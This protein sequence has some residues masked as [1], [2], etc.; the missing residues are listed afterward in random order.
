MEGAGGHLGGSGG[1]FGGFMEGAGASGHL[2][3]SGGGF[4]GFMEGAGASGHLGGGSGGFGGLMEGAGATGH[5]GGSRDGGSGGVG[6]MAGMGVGGFCGTGCA[7]TYAPPLDAGQYMS[8]GATGPLPG[9]L[10]CESACGAYRAVRWRDFADTYACYYDQ[11]GSLVSGRVMGSCS[12]PASFESGP[13]VFC[14][15]ADGGGDAASGQ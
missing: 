3:G 9:Q 12:N 8:C 4:A 7:P 15:G 1:G 13:D 11:A 14:P 2:G 5:Q 6:G 10:A